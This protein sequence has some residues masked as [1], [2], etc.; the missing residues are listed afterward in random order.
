MEDLI[1]CK[2]VA[3][4][5]VSIKTIHET[6]INGMILGYRPLELDGI[7][8]DYFRSQEAFGGCTIMK[9]YDLLPKKNGVNIKHFLLG[10]T[11]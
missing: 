4:G 6:G 1:G 8:A 7:E 5:S 11:K 2:T 9:N 3:Q 10:V